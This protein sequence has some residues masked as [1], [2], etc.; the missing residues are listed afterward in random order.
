MEKII[1]LD[2]TRLG[3]AGDSTRKYFEMTRTRIDSKNG[4]TRPSLI[5]PVL[6]AFLEKWNLDQHSL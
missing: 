6:D 4:L 1:R 2:L 5:N 3:N